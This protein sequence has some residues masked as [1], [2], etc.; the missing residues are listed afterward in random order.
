MQRR[1]ADDD[2][3]EEH[4]VIADTVKAMGLELVPPREAP[5]DLLPQR[6]GHER[7]EEGEGE[8]HDRGK[9]GPSP[10]RPLSQQSDKALLERTIE[11]SARLLCQVEKSRSIRLHDGSL[12]ARPDQHRT[13]HDGRFRPRPSSRVTRHT[14]A[15]S[16]KVQPRHHIAS[17]RVE[18]VEAHRGAF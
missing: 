5:P 12:D 18:A 2:V 4:D 17:T 9:A 8:A 16:G 3:V 11:P 7:G 6:V 15:F 13:G 10:P 1:Y 14:G